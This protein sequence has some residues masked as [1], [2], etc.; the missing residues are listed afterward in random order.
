[1]NPMPKHT[2][3]YAPHGER[4]IKITR[5]FDAPRSAVYHA[6]TQ[7][8]MLKRWMIGPG[9]WSLVTCN[10]DLRVGGTY[11]YVWR[12]NTEGTEMGMH[13]T[14][15][16]IVPNERIS[17]T[18]NFDVDWTGGETLATLTLTEHDGQ[19]TLTNTIRYST[20]EARDNVLASNMEQGVAA[21]YDRLEELLSG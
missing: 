21:G 17:Q 8:E 5:L 10:S 12:H 14:F 11:R 15:C 19:T 9:D 1:M 7:P 6:V 18:E 16:E 2:L 20:P 13:G 4:E 3:H